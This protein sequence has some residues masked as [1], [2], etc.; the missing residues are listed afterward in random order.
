[1][2][3]LFKTGLCLLVIMLSVLVPL[4]V[5]VTAQSGHGGSTQVI[6]FVLGESQEESEEP[7][8]LPSQDESGCDDNTTVPTGDE[9]A[10]YALIPLIIS[11]GA[12]I[13]TGFRIRRKE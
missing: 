13:V 2:K 10:W 4:M 7:E 5:T 8:P 9:F 11:G 3:H 6:A 12:L 1:M